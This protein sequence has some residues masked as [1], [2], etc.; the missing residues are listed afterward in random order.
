MRYAVR[1]LLDFGNCE[2]YE[3]PFDPFLSPNCLADVTRS[4]A[5]SQA[6]TLAGEP[7]EDVWTPTWPPNGP[8]SSVNPSFW[9][10][11]VEGAI[12][13]VTVV[14]ADGC[15]LY[16]SPAVLALAGHS[17]ESRLGTSVFELLVEDDIPLAQAIFRTVLDTPEQPVS[18]DLRVRH[19]N[20][21]VR[22]VRLNVQ[23][24]LHDPAVRGVVINAYDITELK[25]REEELQRSERRF[26]DLVEASPDSIVTVDCEGRV[27][28]ANTRCLRQFGFDPIDLDHLA[29]RDLVTAE[30]QELLD[31][32]LQESARDPSNPPIT[33]HGHV[34]A[35]RSDGST[36]PTEFTV[37]RI[38]TGEGTQLVCIFRDITRRKHSEVEIRRLST[39][40]EHDPSPVMEA[41]RN[42]N[43]V[44][45][46]PA[47]LELASTL[48]LDAGQLLPFAHEDI[49]GKCLADPSFTLQIEAAVNDHVILWQYKPIDDAELVRLYGTDITAKRRA[50]QRVAYE[51][52]HDA[53]TGLANR[54]LFKSH[55]EEAL[56]RCRAVGVGFAVVMLDLDRFKVVNE[57]LGHVAGNTMLVEVSR[58]LSGLLPAEG[59]L[60]RFGGDEFAILIEEAE[61]GANAPRLAEAIQA[62]LSTPFAIAGEEVYTSASIGIAYG[63][64]KHP[65]ADYVI[66]DAERAMY[67]AKSRGKA[68]HAVNEA[69]PDQHT[70]RQLSLETRLRKAIGR[71][72]FVL[73]YQPIVSLESGAIAGFESLVRW[74]N[75][76]GTLVSPADFIPLAED[77][78]LI[79]GIG[80]WVLEQTCSQVAAWL[81]DGL[82]P[83]VASVNISTRQFHQERLVEN[84]RRTVDRH[85]LD[86]RTVK[87]EITETTAATDLS[88][89]S[90]TLQQLKAFGIGIVIDDFGTGY[91]SLSHLQR[92]PIDL[93]KIDRSFVSTTTS[94][95][96][97]DAIVR[98][99]VAMAHSLGLE[100]VA[101]GV[102]TREQ[103]DLLFRL[104]VD[105]I[106]GFL[107]S[108][109]VPADAFR[110]M[111]ERDV[112]L[113]YRPVMA[114]PYRKP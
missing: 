36:F 14:D 10:R 37:S 11:I 34:D 33:V 19:A 28:F 61:N 97:S 114:Q 32:H 80:D 94:H 6:E 71:D 45:A 35:R 21:S 104:R 88:M 93:L 70:R 99:I 49:V 59:M 42:G 105:Y 102:E 23:N 24:F 38:A 64:S 40:P 7:D 31:H 2:A 79:V 72:E 18:S 16:E 56:H 101:E 113:D 110:S 27:L 53:V 67:R 77:T 84:V 90:A 58:R 95:P 87:L 43:L 3:W 98:A 112:R 17:P 63:S 46:N 44:F 60:A 55:V 20:G 106:Q 82:H 92:F 15:V 103:L 29:F 12:E 85:G 50:E 86:P 1:A 107:F 52:L 39:F 26:R 62:G 73:H 91:S 51:T 4:P 83:G 109:P 41:D 5:D 48:H 74:R 69:E 68:Q 100:V 76:D 25:A 89:I 13:A 57:S 78:G 47:A 75:R 22:V 81:R 111:L 65:E 54:V 108:R 66:G 96:D 30:N 8:V 9:R